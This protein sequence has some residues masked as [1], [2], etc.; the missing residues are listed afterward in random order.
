MAGKV[1]VLCMIG[2]A[3]IYNIII[4]QTGS[5]SSGFEGS[6]TSVADYAVAFYTCMWSYG[7]WERVCQEGLK[8]RTIPSPIRSNYLSAFSRFFQQS[9]S[10]KIKNHKEKSKISKNFALS[11]RP[12]K[13]PR[14]LNPSVSALKK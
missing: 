2:G 9:L 14:I 11:L 7:G 6:S 4:G 3:G 13:F 10:Q 1:L 12:K 5:L 8:M